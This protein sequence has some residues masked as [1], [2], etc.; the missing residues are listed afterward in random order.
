MTLLYYHPHFLDHLTGT[1]PE[2][3][4][5][6]LQVIGHLEREQLLT[7]C[8]REP[9]EPISDG[10][11]ARV[12]QPEYAARLQ[13]F[14]DA[15]G[16]RIEA[17]T[18]VS[19]ASYDVARLG[20]GAVSDAVDRVL[21]GQEKTAL[22]LV[23][24]PGHHAL[25]YDAM[26]FCLFNNVAIG[27]RVATAEFQLDRVLIVDWDVHH[28]NGTQDTFWTDPKVGFFSIHRWPFYPGTG[29]RDET[30]SAAGL[31][32]T[33]NVPIEFGTSRADYL[34]Q[35][36][37]EIEAFADRLKPQLVI[38]SA[39]FDSHRDDP[40]GSLGL[41]I[42]DFDVLTQIVID[43]ANT[44]AAGRI[45]SVLEGGYNPGILAGCVAVH[46]QKLLAA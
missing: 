45:V 10:R 46:L 1:H 44:H 21:R 23:R 25:A 32:T 3:P 35:F 34:A 36:R 37:N 29:D 9:W 17:D 4:A 22:C 42:E 40:V 38:I 2:R 6:L 19:A 41:E 33:L 16:G 43:I 11:L 27:A 7:Q 18:V 31:G 24:P 14:T 20:A 15:G 39:G 12:H 13:T 28:G 8:R 30:G 26:G 5:R